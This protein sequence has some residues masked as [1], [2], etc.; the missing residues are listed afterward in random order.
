MTSLISKLQALKGKTTEGPHEFRHGLNLFKGNRLIANFAGHSST[1]DPERI[2]A[3]NKANA[4]LFALAPE[5]AKA[6]LAIAHLH[7][8]HELTAGG[9]TKPCCVQ[10]GVLDEWPCPTIR[11]L[12]PDDGD[13]P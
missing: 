4:E 8:F 9:V 12:S 6:L 10:C 11:A 1:I 13:L 7:Q 5:M 2:D 3:E